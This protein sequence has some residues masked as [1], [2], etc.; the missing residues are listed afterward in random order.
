M[1]LKI[2]KYFFFIVLGLIILTALVAT[3]LIIKARNEGNRMYKMYENYTQ[4]TLAKNFQLKPY[5]VKQEYQTIHP[6]KVLKLLKFVITSAE[7]ERFK[8]VNTLDATIGLF[9]KMYT[10]FIL[11]NYNYNLPML[12]V[13]IIFIGGNR[14]FV[15]EIIDP[16]QIKDNNLE[17]HYEKMRAKKTKIEDLEKME[18]NMEWAENVVT[19][20]S[21]HKRADRTHD[22][23]LFEIYKHYLNTYIE[24]AKN[25]QPHSPGLS[26]KVKQGMEW[27]VDTLLAK[28]GPA[29]NVFKT[30]LG[31]EKQKEYVRTVMFGVD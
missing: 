22:E 17:T 25:A 16:A 10:L 5:P 2:L 19:D 9:M 11:P 31:P 13:D 15:I 8:R 26:E 4:E 14:V 12:S 20:F 7:G 29:V 23:L 6:W 21:I 24:M 28:G 1:I 18:V 3:P 27:Y 30:I